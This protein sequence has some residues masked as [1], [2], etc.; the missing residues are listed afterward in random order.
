MSAFW[1]DLIK[2]TKA[3]KGHYLQSE[4]TQERVKWRHNKSKAIKQIILLFQLCV[5][6]DGLMQHLSS[7][8]SL[9]VITKPH[10]WKKPV[11]MLNEIC[12]FC[13]VGNF[14]KYQC[15][16]PNQSKAKHVLNFPHEIKATLEKKWSSVFKCKNK[17]IFWNKMFFNLWHV[18]LFTTKVLSYHGSK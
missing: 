10:Q 7:R 5:K 9:F 3:L 17:T 14:K 15:F 12:N 4:E 2:E 1:T 11:A 8:M 13:F 18:R 16:C 6:S